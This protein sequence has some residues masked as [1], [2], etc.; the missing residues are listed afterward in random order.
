MIS[1]AFDKC[2][3]TFDED[4]AIDVMCSVSINTIW[5]ILDEMYI[6]IKQIKAV[7]DS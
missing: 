2:D 7:I 5:E 6:L 4:L 3:L 1:D